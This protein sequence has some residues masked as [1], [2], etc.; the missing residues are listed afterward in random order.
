M[1]LDINLVSYH[2]QRVAHERE[3][4]YVLSDR[5]KSFADIYEQIG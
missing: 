4:D 1:A 2:G 3:Q 5:D